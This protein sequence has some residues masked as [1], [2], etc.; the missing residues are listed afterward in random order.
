MVGQI[1]RN[2]NRVHSKTCSASFHQLI[3]TR[4]VA[5]R[6]D[7]C[8][9]L[10][11]AQKETRYLTFPRTRNEIISN[12]SPCVH[13]HKHS[14]PTPRF[15]VLYSTRTRQMK[16]AR[17]RRARKIRGMFFVC[18][19]R[20][21]CVSARVREHYSRTREHA[22]VRGVILAKQSNM[23][24]AS[25]RIQ[26]A[27]IHLDASASVYGRERVCFWSPIRFTRARRKCTHIPVCACV[28]AFCLV[29][30]PR[31]G[32]AGANAVRIIPRLCRIV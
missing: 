9:T 19:C 29:C 26:R 7:V 2:P 14:Q 20:E 27:W 5:R 13:R 16:L 21:G 15:A 18:L 12:T 22:L 4:C 3:S 8:V 17:A 11:I 32:E 6:S 25:L 1:R 24:A 23:A 30:V 28:P 31:R 10:M